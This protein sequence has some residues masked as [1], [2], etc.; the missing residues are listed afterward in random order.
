MLQ[1]IQK[2]LRYDL[3]KTMK[4]KILDLTQMKK[5]L[6]CGLDALWT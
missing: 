2:S 3:F 1:K 6:D 4:K 5:G